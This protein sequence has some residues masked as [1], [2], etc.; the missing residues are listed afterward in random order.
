M[1]SVKNVAV[2]RSTGAHL[3]PYMEQIC[4]VLDCTLE[5]AQKDEYDLSHTVLQGA[6]AWLSH[7]RWQQPTS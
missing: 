7:I 3:L 1:L 6:L 5:L 2:Y 4:S